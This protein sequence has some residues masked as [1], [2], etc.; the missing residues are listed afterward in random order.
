MPPSLTP[1]MCLSLP[2]ISSQPD[3]ATM[4]Q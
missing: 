3:L 1:D 2:D 4:R